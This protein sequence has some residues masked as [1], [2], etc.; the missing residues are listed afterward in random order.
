MSGFLLCYPP[1]PHLQHISETV[2]SEVGPYLSL[3]SLGSCLLYAVYEQG[4]ASLLFFLLVSSGPR[5]P[6]VFLPV[7]HGGRRRMG[8]LTRAEIR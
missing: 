8:K 6:Q 5:N 3:D 4:E 1:R 2:V 7:Q